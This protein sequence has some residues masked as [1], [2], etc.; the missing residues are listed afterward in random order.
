VTWDDWFV[1]RYEPDPFGGC[2]L[3]V[4]KRNDD[5]YGKFNRESYRGLAHRKSY[6]VAI[7]PIPDG[8]VVMHTCDVS[9]CVNPNHLRAGTQL[10]NIADRVAK[11]RSRGGDRSGENSRVAKLNWDMVRQ[12]RTRAE[13]GE[14]HGSIAKDFPV[15][16][17]AITAVV[18]GKKWI[19]YNGV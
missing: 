8:C 15:S 11:G 12:I 3:W 9:C 16:R 18:A 19:N 13:N 5:G 6:E 14:S 2:L 4:G 10:D 7:G 1:G 17:S